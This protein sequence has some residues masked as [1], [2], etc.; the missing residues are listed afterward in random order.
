M[1]IIKLNSCVIH[2]SYSVLRIITERWSDEENRTS[3]H[4]TNEDELNS[5]EHAHL[6]CHSVSWPV[7]LNMVRWSA[8]CGAHVILYQ[9]HYVRLTARSTYKKR[10]LQDR[11][12][13][14]RNAACRGRLGHNTIW[15]ICAITCEAA[16]SRALPT[17]VTVHS[18]LL[19]T[20][21]CW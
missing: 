14:V 11:G 1:I 7:S 2:P 19:L 4:I 9:L 18:P 10:V 8:T 6:T 15:T 3:R 20:A 21:Y 17:I 12:K 16:S 5:P 13:L